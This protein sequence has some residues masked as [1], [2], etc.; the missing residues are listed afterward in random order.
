MAVSTTDQLG[1]HTAHDI[2]RY[3]ADGDWQHEVL[4]QIV[5]R[6]AGERTDQVFVSDGDT[7]FTYGELYDRAVRLATGLRGLGVE[8]GDRVAVQLPNW[9][10]FAV[11]VVAISRLGAVLV[12]IMP[13]FR[14]DEVNYMVG[15]S[16]AVVSISPEF[17]H[18]F[19][20]REMYREVR[21]A[22]PGLRHSLIVRGDRPGGDSESDLEAFYAEGDL[23][24]L[25]AALG[26]PADADEPCLIVY[27]SGTTSRPKGCLHTFNTIHA[28]AKAMIARLGIDDSDVFFNPSP[29][30]H[31][32]GLV[33]GLL[34]PILAGAGTHFQPAW[35]PEDGLRRIAEYGCTVTYTATTFIS[36]VMQ[37]YE[38][39]RHDVSSMRY[40]VCAGAPIPGAIVQAARSLFPRCSV[41]SLYGRS[42]NMTTT[43][44]GPDD[45]PER[46][47]TSDGRAL[48]SA[49]VIAVDRQGVRVP[50]GTEGDLAYHGPSHMLEYYR[51]PD[52]TAALY[53]ADGFSRSGDLGIQDDQGFVRVSGRVKDIIIRGGL[54][55]SSREVEDLLSGHPAIRAVAVVAMPDARLGEKS[56][57][58]VVPAADADP[59]TL[60]DVNEY[61]QAHKVAV[62]KQPERLEI[63]EELPMTAVG[64]IRK[65]VL[66]DQ[67][68]ATLR[69][70]LNTSVNS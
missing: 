33:T 40:W 18:K 13:I 36:T 60:V 32:T 55:I 43:M 64:K 10:E 6:Q 47:V 15:H 56:C 59:L 35:D 54:N 58:F 69:A 4:A 23:A 31:S 5:Q 65:N 37:A 21:A 24:E 57:A 42:E 52:Q 12:P 11:A 63:V 41:L 2:A 67:I 30:S 8:R 3:Y 61:L 62:Q 9:A 68:A 1:P 28:S 27:T 7:S 39:G 49:D 45:A 29:V 46:S 34:M 25:D 66:R 26:A 16:G 48:P 70:E 38:E 19:D 51:D 17:F 22:T 14:F 44:C 53:T 50:N 20:Y